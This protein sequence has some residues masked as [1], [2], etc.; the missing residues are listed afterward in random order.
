MRRPDVLAMLCGKAL[1]RMA[2]RV[3]GRLP[4]CIGFE[5][6]TGLEGLLRWSGRHLIKIR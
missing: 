2:G 3:A 5:A 4:I 6:Y 1:L